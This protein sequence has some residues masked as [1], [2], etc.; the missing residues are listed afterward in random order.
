MMLTRRTLMAAAPLTGLATRVRA[1]AGPIRF[2]VGP[3]QPTAGDTCRAYE[4]FLS[5]LAAA[6]GRPFGLTVTTD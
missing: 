1:Q 5:D 4:P 3:F 2:A 6:L